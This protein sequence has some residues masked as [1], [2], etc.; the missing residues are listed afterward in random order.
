VPWTKCT[1]NSGQVSGWSEH[2]KESFS[3]PKD[4]TETFIL[5]IL[6]Y[7]LQTPREIAEI[8]TSTTGFWKANTSLLQKTLISIQAV[9]SW[10]QMSN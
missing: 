9:F 1:N 4:L 7:L 5:E 6:P 2:K 10:T 3:P 8:D